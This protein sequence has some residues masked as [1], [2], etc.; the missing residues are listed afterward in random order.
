[1]ALAVTAAVVP[2]PAGV[3][4]AAPAAVITGVVLVTPTLPNA[5]LTLFV[6]SD[7]TAATDYRQVY[8]L[9]NK[10]LVI[11]VGSGGFFPIPQNI[12]PIGAKIQVALTNFGAA[13]A[14]VNLVTA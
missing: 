7:P 1:M 13:S 2:F 12:I 14:T 6:G 11:P 8:G 10:P 5:V 4:A 3:V 9:D